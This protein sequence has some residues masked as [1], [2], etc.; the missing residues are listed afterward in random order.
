MTEELCKITHYFLCC[1]IA[2]CPSQVNLT[3]TV[4]LH[5]LVE[6]LLTGA[7]VGVQLRNPGSI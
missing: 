6:A 5:I 7:D 3:G 4:G 1:G 2:I